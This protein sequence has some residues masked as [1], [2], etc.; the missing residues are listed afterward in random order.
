MALLGI[1]WLFSNVSHVSQ[2]AGAAC[3]LM[4]AEVQ[5]TEEKHKSF[6][7]F[8]FFKIFICIKFTLAYRVRVSDMV[9]PQ[10]SVERNCQRVWI[11]GCSSQE[12]TSLEFMPK[13]DGIKR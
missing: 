7:F 12:C 2:K 10:V 4:V 1:S 9:K 6:F 5:E 11:Q 13:D 8:F 3:S